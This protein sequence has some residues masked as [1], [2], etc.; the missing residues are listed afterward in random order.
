VSRAAR[1]AK[2][3]AAAD[4]VGRIADAV[5][6]LHDLLDNFFDEHPAFTGKLEEAFPDHKE[7]SRD[8]IKRLNRLSNDLTP[9]DGGSR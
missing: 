7:I 2:S 9:P 4:A 5:K 1:E 6:E 8:V 3:Q